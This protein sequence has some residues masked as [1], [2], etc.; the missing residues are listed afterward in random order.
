V[1]AFAEVGAWPGVLRQLTGGADLSEAVARGAMEKILAGEATDAQVAALIVGLRIKGESPAEVVGLAGAML[2]AAAP[3]HLDEPDS[4]IDLV[5]T[6]GSSVFGGSAFNVSTM[7]SIVAAGA[8]ATVCKHGNRKASSASG[9]TDLLEALGVAVELDGPGV[10]TCVREAGVG[11]AFARM[12]HPSM[13]HVAGVRAEL[14]IPTV[15]NVLGP[16]SHPGRVTRQVL[17]VADPR[18]MD[19]VPEVLAR[20]GTVHSWV[21]HGEG[22]LDELT[23]AGTTSV[24]EV[25]GDRI[26]HLTFT[27]EDVGLAR[28]TLDRLAVGGPEENAAAAKD[29]LAGRPGPVRDMVVL[30]AAAGLVVA[31]LAGDLAEGVQLAGT[32][33]DDGRAARV[34]G[35]L[36]AVSRAAAARDDDERP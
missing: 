30:N 1:G 4:T 33:I 2:D 18:L 29:V 35:E 15:F 6:G 22:G 13:R 26:R 21:V 12:F 7:A 36:V 16:L 28:V 17:G 9:S 32:A 25:V 23:T 24:A 8:G 31:G 5:G 11:F 10:A 14:G 19:L 3:L 20:R 27:P 34:L